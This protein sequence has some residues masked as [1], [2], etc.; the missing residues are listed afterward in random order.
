MSIPK[1]IGL[2]TTAAVLV[3]VTVG[4]GPTDRGGAASSSESTTTSTSMTTSTRTTAATSVAPTPT[5]EPIGT[6]T[7]SMSGAT[8]PVTITYSI[9]G[10]PEQ[11]E[12]D[13]VLPWSKDY[14]VYPELDTWVKAADGDAEMTCTITM[15]GKL[16]SF[17]T[18]PRPTC[19]FAY[20]G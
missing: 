1:L 19:S 3:G 5:G 7:M 10:G 11:T 15:D 6:A 9:N 13:V 16:A 20:W 4:C 12:A 17:K 14:P 2:A 8:R 18:E